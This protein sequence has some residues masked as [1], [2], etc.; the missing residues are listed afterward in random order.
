MARFVSCLLVSAILLGG[1]GVCQYA[2]TQRVEISISNAPDTHGHSETGTTDQAAT[3]Y[4]LALT[5]GFTAGD[6]PFA[7]RTSGDGTAPRLT[8]RHGA[9]DLYV[10]TDE[11]VR[12]RTISV[13]NL[14]FSGDAVTLFVEAVPGPED[15]RNPCPLRLQLS[16]DGVAC[17]GATL[18]SEGD[19]AR[20][21]GEVHLSLAPRLES[22][23]RGLGER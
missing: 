20:L 5:L 7:V 19:G 21:S 1:V 3:P 23:D 22:L 8:L 10:T 11:L 17:G 6:D 9:R 16:R 12:G 13:T 15:A 4:D 18:W 14:A 2:L